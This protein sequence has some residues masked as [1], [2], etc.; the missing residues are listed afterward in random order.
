MDPALSVI[1]SVK[2]AGHRLEETIWSIL[3]QSYDSLEFIIVNDGD[4]PEIRTITDSI[5]D[6][7]LVVLNQPWQGLTRSLNDALQISHGKYIARTDAGDFSYPTRFEAQIT[8]LESHPEV[9]LVGTAFKEESTEGEV[10][11]E[12]ILPTG[13]TELKNNLQFQNQFC[14]GTVMFRKKCLSEVGP[15]RNEFLKAQDYDFWLRIADKFDIANLPEVLYKRRV[16]KNSISID[17]RDIQDQYAQIARDC[18]EARHRD[19][20]EP[21]HKTQNIR[22]SNGT[23]GWISKRRSRARYNFHLGRHSLKNRQTADA[24][25]LFLKGIVAWPL[26]SHQWFFLFATLFPIRVIDQ[27]EPLWKKIQRKLGIHI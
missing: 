21:L 19:R 27:I 25:L 12:V 26:F 1:M 2:S 18:A 3:D 4:E 11:N 24:R 9:G 8:F 22:A 14:H 23:D 20:P 5:T 16:E 6:P 15:Y 7:R 13:N 10:V 17:S